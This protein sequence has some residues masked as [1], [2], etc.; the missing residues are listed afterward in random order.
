MQVRT[1]WD[2]KNEKYWFSVVDI[3]AIL[4]DQSTSRGATFYWGTLK[5]RLKEE[6]SELLT[7]CQQLKQIKMM[8]IHN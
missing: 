6:G 7:N 8:M 4:T 5:Q 3:V 2:K 1:E